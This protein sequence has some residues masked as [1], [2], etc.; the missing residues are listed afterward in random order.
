MSSTNP[1]HPTE[2]T[3]GQANALLAEQ[4]KPF[5]IHDPFPFYALARAGAPLFYHAEL[6][7]WVVTRYEDIK[8]IFKDPETFSSEVTQTPYKPRPT[9]VQRVLDEGG[10]TGNSGLSGRV[11]PDHTRLRRF[12]NKAFTPRRVQALEPR[13]RELTTRMIDAFA[14]DGHADLVAQLVYELP[15]LVIFILLGIPEADVPNVKT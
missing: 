5:E 6:G 4:F 13:I 2:S 11:P 15:A 1:L 12:I 7:Y 3:T 9:E 8:A 14:N 10:F